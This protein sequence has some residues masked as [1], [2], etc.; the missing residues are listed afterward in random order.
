MEA[1]AEA[2]VVHSSLNGQRAISFS[3]REISGYESLKLKGKDPENN[4]DGVKIGSL[5]L[6]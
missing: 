5:S 1:R 3:Y 4:N 6:L 2:A